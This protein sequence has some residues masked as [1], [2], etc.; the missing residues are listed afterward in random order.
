MSAVAELAAL[1]PAA[2]A[3]SLRSAAPPPAEECAAAVAAAL[4]A[5]PR[6]LDLLAALTEPE[7]SPCAKDAAGACACTHEAAQ[8]AFR[9]G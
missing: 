6:F 5:H 9:S 1:L 2:L 7:G 4:D 8:R 3:A